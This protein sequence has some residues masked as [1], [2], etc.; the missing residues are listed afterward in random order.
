[1]PKLMP[2]KDA[3]SFVHRIRELAK[4]NFR[5]LYRDPLSL[6]LLLGFPIVFITVMGIAF[7]GQVNVTFLLGVVDEDNSAL[8]QEFISDFL[9]GANHLKIDNYD[10]ASQAKESLQRG[11]V[12]A[13]LVI[14]EG[15]G[16][17]ASQCQQGD[18]T[19]LSLRVTCDESSK[20]TLERMTAS[21]QSE[22]QYFAKIKRNV[23]ITTGRIHN[24][25]IT[26]LDL[27]APGLIV[28]GLLILIPTSARMIVRDREKGFLS[29]L[30]TAPVRPF[31]FIASYFICLMAIA[32][33]Q[34][35]V[36]LVVGTRFGLEM[37]GNPLL[38]FLSLFLVSVSSI[39]IGMLIASVV[40]NENQAEPL[41]WLVTMPMAM[42][43]GAW[44]AMGFMPN[45]VRAVAYAFPFSHAVDISRG[46]MIRGAGWDMLTNDLLFLVIWTVAVLFAATF[47][48]RRRMVA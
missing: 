21:I 42:I 1:M 39:S 3:Y 25:N 45:W 16:E 37:M 9:V 48:F 23:V 10:D 4:R 11:D 40:S 22:V 41:S 33:L 7:G 31:D 24:S 12:L 43:S 17:W 34:I 8:S 2:L 46:V 20:L 36:F 15:F 14:P 27:V 19:P 47:L 18:V 5:E 6:G 32:I 38:V 44:F 13:Y 28:F 35:I 29:R 30:L 26:Y